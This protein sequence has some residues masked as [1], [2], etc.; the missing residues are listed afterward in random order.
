MRSTHYCFLFFSLLLLAS[1]TTFGQS[2][3]VG[4]VS[5]SFQSDVQYL[6]EDPIIGADDVEERVLSNTY[7]Q[8]Q[9]GE[10]RKKEN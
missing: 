5:G 3:S 6:F 4:R 1:A 2:L 9:A 7:M 8:K 10:E